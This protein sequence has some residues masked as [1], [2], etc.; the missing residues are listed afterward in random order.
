[1]PVPQSLEVMD[2]M[3][4]GGDYVRINYGNSATHSQSG[5]YALATHYKCSWRMEG[6]QGFV[7]RQLASKAVGIAGVNITPAQILARS[8]GQILN[9]N[10]ELLFNGPS[11]AHF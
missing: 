9:P 5:L 6:T 2:T 7:T 10:M 4:S 8:T 1:M 3:E 11:L